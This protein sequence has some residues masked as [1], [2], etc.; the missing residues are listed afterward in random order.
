[1]RLT[2]GKKLTISF[3]CL[4]CLVLLAGVVGYFVVKRVSHSAD[5]VASE[6]VPLQKAVMNAALSVEQ[7]Q[8]STEQYLHAVNG[9]LDELAEQLNVRLDEFGMWIALIKMGSNS[10]EFQNSPYAELYRQKGLQIIVPAGTEKIRL[11]ADSILT[12]YDT[13]KHHSAALI[14]AHREYALYAV[15]VG[16]KIYPLPDFLN[17]VQREHLEWLR[18]LKDAVNIETT[19]VGERDPGGGAIGQWLTTYNV[20]TQVSDL[21]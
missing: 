21:P 18:Q 16:E 15:P 19:F 17:L 2:I 4:A 13:L 12:Q 14:Q 11:T 20:N 9:G 10:D 8:L 5:V 3:L 1:M 6:Q 7:V